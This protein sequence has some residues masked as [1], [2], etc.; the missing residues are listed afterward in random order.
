M[1]SKERK[2]VQGSERDPL[3]GARVTRPADPNE[4]IEVTVRVRRRA[5]S[6]DDIASL[7][8]THSAQPHERHHLSHEEFE[9][10]YGAD[11][12]DIEQ[13]EKF[14]KEHN[15]T[16]VESSLPRRS[17]ILSGKVADM[18]DAFGVSLATYEH[19]GGKY[20]GRTGSIHV[21]AEI[22]HI[23]EGVFG[24]DNRPQATPFFRH[25][26][27]K[28]NTATP[29]Q[30]PPIS[31]TPLQLAKLYDFPDGDG[32][33]QCIAMIEL[34]GGYRSADLNAYFSQLDIHAPKITAVSVDHCHN[35]PIGDPVSID[36]EVMMDIEVAAAIV[37]KA[38][39]VVY[40][41]PNTSRGFV[42]SITKAIHDTQHKPTIL[43]ISWGGP[44][45]TWSRQ[46]MITID[47]ALQSAAALGI[48][49]T[50]A[51]GD[52]GFGD[53]VA[54][55]HAHVN[56]PASSPHL[57]ACGGTKL[58]GSGAKIQSEVVWN[59][60]PGHGATGGGISDVFAVPSYQSKSKIPSSINPGKRKGRGIPDVAGNADPATGYK[61]R[62]D[63]K[64]VVLGGT[65]A[66][67]PLW[68]ALVALINQKLQRNV[69]FIN[70]ELYNGSAGSHAL[71]DITLGNNGGY[72]ARAGWDACTG[73]GTPDGK[74]ILS[75]LSSTTK[76]KAGKG[77]HDK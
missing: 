13:I 45:N 20:R 30:S 11:P 36:G 26:K 59:D 33:G 50:C 21:P 54:D 68:A 44:E 61:V 27:P 5:D 57:L 19:P 64:E 24:L 73:L 12:K 40:F 37:P 10:T 56:F 49:I 41:A 43:S 71:H 23:I 47:N 16:V 9:K 53:G 63:G 67:A 70:P 32:A 28:E 6:K 77:K 29:T 25:F 8:E 51:A 2:T 46:A 39:I 58:V 31:Y 76:S 14:A 62:V 17:V 55:G 34:G 4:Q 66:V 48:T 18:S 60:G 7:I 65:S 38:S 74:A 22:H 75:L 72:S 15:L 52:H 69:G 1:P 35:S 42:D 3:P